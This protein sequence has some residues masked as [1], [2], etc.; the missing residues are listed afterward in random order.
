MK[1]P[2][3]DDNHDI[4]INSKYFN[5]NEMNAL[6]TKEN[7]FSILHLNI[8]C[9]NKHLDGLSNLLSSMKSNF[10]IISLSAHKIG[11]NTPINN[12]SLPGHAFCFDEAKSTH[13]G[14]GFFINK[15]YTYIK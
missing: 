2:S 10:P 7:H 5:I 3:D 1:V 12:I 6:K 15:K 14:T 4:L 8:V 13:G 9:L 11:L